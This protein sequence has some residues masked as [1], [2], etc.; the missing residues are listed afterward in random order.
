MLTGHWESV[1]AGRCRELQTA[2][3]HVRRLPVARWHGRDRA[4]DTLIRTVAEWCTGPTVELGCGPGRFVAHLL[5]RQ[6]PALGIDDAPTAIRLTRDRGAAAVQRDVFAP[7]P[8]EGRW[9]HVVLL[10]GNVGIGGDP[11]RLVRRA[12]ELIEPKGTIMVEVEPAVRGVLREAVRLNVAGGAT[13]WFPWA[14]VG[15]DG[16]GVLA[17]EARLRIVRRIECGGRMCVELA[18]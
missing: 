12:L 17:H 2:D 5:R 7:L 14:R 3:G 1:M 6:V 11:D 8:G 10:D 9:S 15:A 4:D 13:E 18:R 16:I